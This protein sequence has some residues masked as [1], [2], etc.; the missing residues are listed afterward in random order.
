MANLKRGLERQQAYAKKVP[1]GRPRRA[2]VL[3]F[4][5]SGHLEPSSIRL[6]DSGDIS[7]WDINIIISGVR[8]GILR[9]T[10]WGTFS[11]QFENRTASFKKFVEAWDWLIRS[12]F[13]VHPHDPKKLVYKRQDDSVVSHLE[14]P[15][16][17]VAALS[18]LMNEED[19]AKD[20]Y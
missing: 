11:V 20:L 13:E 6:N 19:R 1:T 12:K 7:T 10:H 17:S 2:Q 14:A 3:T 5:N 9:M 18:C 8:A 4:V 15:A 16:L